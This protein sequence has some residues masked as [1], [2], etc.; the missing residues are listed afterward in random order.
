MIHK[1]IIACIFGA[2]L[3]GTVYWGG[4]R[5][6]PD[7]TVE[8]LPAADQVDAT[9]GAQT[10]AI[11][12]AT[13]AQASAKPTPKPSA[14]PGVTPSPAPT[15]KP[16]TPI[17]HSEL[18]WGAYVGWQDGALD[19]F[20]KLVGNKV[21]ILADFVSW[22]NEKDF[23]SQY[24]ATVRDK[25]KTLLIYWEAEDYNNEVPNDARFGYDSILAGKWDSYFK[26][27]AAAAKTYGGPVILV[28][29][30]EMN[31]NVSPWD[32]TVN[33]NTPAKHIAAFR[34][35]RDIFRTAAPNVKFGWAVNSLSVPDV[36]GNQI[37]NYYPGDSY[38]DYVGVDGFNF[39]DPWQSFDQVFDPA[40]KKLVAYN[41]P[42]YIFSMASREGDQKADWIKEGLGTHISTYS[43]VVG[44]IWF[45]ENKSDNGEYDWL[46]NS[47]AKSLAA[48]KSIIPWGLFHSSK[49]LVTRLPLYKGYGLAK[50]G[51][52]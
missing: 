23:P 15:A 37:E 27:F 42:I 29:F 7:P 5:K 6:H 26:Q 35:I 34:R 8:T 12:K 31:D 36:A 25:G 16:A 10:S 30:D 22:G 13:T 21:D 38:V 17:A 41:K 28:P 50:L 11:V 2:S 18:R 32:G 39:G 14:K 51:L 1:L 24:G 48:F 52:L 4:T 44:W 40:M 20:E 46:V 3:L 33:N 49:L 45:N 43:N 9:S 19:S 47:D